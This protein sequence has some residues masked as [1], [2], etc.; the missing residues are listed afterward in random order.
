MNLPL[1]WTPKFL[2]QV[3]CQLVWTDQ[4]AENNFDQFDISQLSS[5]S[6]TKCKIYVGFK[7][8]NMT[9]NKT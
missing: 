3:I 7:L 5:C 4:W 2:A 1:I 9:V 8:E 6:Q